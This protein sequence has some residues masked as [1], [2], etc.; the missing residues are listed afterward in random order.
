MLQSTKKEFFM[1]VSDFLWGSP[2]KREKI[3]TL[4]PQQKQYQEYIRNQS[5]NFG[6]DPNYQAGSSWIQQMLS[7]DPEAMKAFEQPFMNNFNQKIIPGLANRFA[8]M[9]SGNQ[10]SSAFQQ[11]LGE[12]GSN[13]QT[14]LASLRANLQQGAS[15][16]ALRYAM[17]PG[18][19]TAALAG[20]GLNPEFAYAERPATQGFLPQMAAAGIKAYAGGF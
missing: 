6:Q 8:G 15:Q 5:M 2:Y 18:Q 13:L 1:S 19:N 20:Y 3:D 14:G 11:A 17:A 16:D 12:A 4:T 10:S 7:A 9:G